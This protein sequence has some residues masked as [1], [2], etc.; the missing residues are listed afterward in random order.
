[1]LAD[2]FDGSSA[3]S[4]L[5]LDGSSSSILSQHGGLEAMTATFN[6]IREVLMEKG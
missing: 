4:G 6:K 2:L 3:Y 5:A 1:L